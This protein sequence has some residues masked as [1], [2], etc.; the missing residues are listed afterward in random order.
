MRV[1]TKFSLAIAFC[2][3]AQALD[4]VSALKGA[5]EAPDDHRHAVRRIQTLIGISR[6][7]EIGIGSHLPAA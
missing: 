6:T 2:F 1:F 4:L 5:I 7:G 3:I